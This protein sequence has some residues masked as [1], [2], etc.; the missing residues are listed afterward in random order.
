MA[1]V[2][3]MEDCLD[4]VKVWMARNAMF[5]NDG[6]TQYLPIVPKSADAIVDKSVIRVGVATI[7]VRFVFSVLVCALISSLTRRSKCRKLSVL[8][9][10]TC[11]TLIKLAAFF[12][13]RQ[14]NALSMPLSHHGLTTVT[15]SY[16]V[17]MQ[18]TSPVYS[19]YITRLPG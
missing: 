1:A 15:H 11:A 14:R 12:P 6:K 18:L 8:A 5:M 2:K 7:T 4:E 17:R 9:L 19:E 16:T 10:S 13:D 3:Q